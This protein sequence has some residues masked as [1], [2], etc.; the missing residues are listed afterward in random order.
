M[1]H[2]LF[3]L[4]E[5]FAR[6]VFAYCRDRLSLDPVPLDYGGLLPI[7]DGVLDNLLSETGHSADKV[8]ALYRDHLAPSI[9]SV[10]ST[11]CLAFIPNAPSKMSSLFDMV[12]AA[13]G[14]AGTNWVEA[15]GAVAAENQALEFLARRAG[16]PAGAGGTFVSGGTAGNLSALTVARDVGRAR[17]PDFAPHEVRIALS[18]EAHSSIGTALHVIGVTPLFVPTDDHRLTR[19]ALEAALARDPHPETVVGVVATAGTTNAGII[20]DLEGLGSFAREHDLWFHVD[21]AYGGAAMFSSSHREQLSGLR[22]ANSFIVDPHK[23][24]FAPFDCCALIYREPTL[25]RDFLAQR[26]DRK[27]VV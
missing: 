12:I 18:E 8:L 13:S 5:E 11:A 17:H 21:G 2:P 20:D 4:D 10:D 27:S 1:T 3:A 16:L 25:A 6:Q 15:A 9:I 26:A 19:R 7:P 24:L 22:H 14:L 23:W